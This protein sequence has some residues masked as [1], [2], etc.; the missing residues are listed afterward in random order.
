MVAGRTSVVGA[1]VEVACWEPGAE[2][3]EL[4]AYSLRQDVYKVVSKDG[5][6]G[7][8]GRLHDSSSSC[9]TTA[10]TAPGV[11]DPRLRAFSTSRYSSICT[12]AR[13]K[14]TQ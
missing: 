5:V 10:A 7:P 14:T 2:L 4:S 11:D 6:V 13:R 9:R 8:E 3:S 12:G 1:V